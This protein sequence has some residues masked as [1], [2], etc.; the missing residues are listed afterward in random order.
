MN[1]AIIGAGIAGLSCAQSL[2]LQGHEVTVFDKSRGP[3][4][5]MSTRRIGSPLGELQFDHGAQYFTARDPSF[6]KELADW[7]EAGLAAPW[8]LAGP[9][10]WVA[11]PSMN[12]LPKAMAKDLDLRCGIHVHRIE[13]RAE[14]WHLVDGAEEFGGFGGYDAVILALPAEQALPM[15]SLHDFSM[16]RQAM[17]APTQPCW[18]AMLAFDEPLSAQS[19]VIRDCG[20][21]GWAVRCASRPGRQ[22]VE[23]WVVQASPQWSAKHLEGHPADALQCLCKGLALAIG[24]TLPEP[25]VAVAHRWRYALSTGLGIG[26]MWNPDLRIGACGDWLLGPRVECAWLSGRHLA[27]RIT[28]NGADIAAVPVQPAQETSG[29]IP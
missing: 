22:Q 4:G 24:T 21:V 27:S 15:L 17:A 12:A 19:D 23:T 13:Q 6:C 1:I 11:M 25:V 20:L 3:G 2:V 14:G 29:L 7:A 16:A 26:S 9:D 28:S 10:A 5:R 18:T 8:L